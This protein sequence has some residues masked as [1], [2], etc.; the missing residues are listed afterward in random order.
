MSPDIGTSVDVRSAE[1]LLAQLRTQTER[2]AVMA[3]KLESVEEAF[4]KMLH[5]LEH[6]SEKLL[7]KIEATNARAETVFAKGHTKADAKNKRLE[8][9]DG[10]L[11]K[12]DAL[13]NETP[14]SEDSNE[15]SQNSGT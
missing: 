4:G 2:K 13:T 1:I 6:H 11:D 10:Y 5:G 12:I 9:I 7:N 14:T 8:A 3:S 15:S